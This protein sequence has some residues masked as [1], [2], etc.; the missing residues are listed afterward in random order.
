MDAQISM[1]HG[2]ADQMAA[3]GQWLN[4]EDELRG[5]VHTA[6]APIGET[7]LGSVTELLTVALSSGGAGTVLATSLKTWLLTRKTTA[8]ITVR[9]A[10][11]TVS[12]DLQTVDEVAPMLEQILNVGNGG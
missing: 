10:G 2:S 3:L 4:Q 8:K 1:T 9:C 7:E 11:R 12:V 5:R 6:R